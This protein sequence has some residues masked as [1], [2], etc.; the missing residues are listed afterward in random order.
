MRGP[1]VFVDG[2]EERDEYFLATGAHARRVAAD[3]AE[4]RAL[5]AKR[6]R[7]KLFH[8]HN[9]PFWQMRYHDGKGGSRDESAH[10]ENLDDAQALFGLSRLSGERGNP[11]RHGELRT[12]HRA[13]AGCG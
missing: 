13:L 2:V 4:L 5:R 8:R 11:T 10:T 7:A 3:L 6:M 1:A 12:N 9:S